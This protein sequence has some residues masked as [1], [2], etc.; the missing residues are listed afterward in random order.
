MKKAISL[1]NLLPLLL[2]L[3]LLLPGAAHA[4]SCTATMTDIVFANVNPIAGSDYYASGTL[5]VTCTV[6]LLGSAGAAGALLPSVS[7]CA[8]LG[9]ASGTRLMANGSATLPFNLY[10]DST[11][12]A[13]SVW[14]TGTA[15]GTSAFKSSGLALLSTGSGSQSFTVYGRIPG[16]AIGTVPTVGNASTD[17]SASFSGLGVLRYAFGTLL[18]PDCSSGASTA[19][20]FQ[21]RATV[22]NDCR[23][24]AGRLD[25]GNVG[26]LSAAVR[27]S[28]S[29]GVQCTAGS[30][31]QIGLNAGTYGSGATRYMKNAGSGETVSYQLSSTLDGV[32]WGDGAT[33]AGAAGTGTGV[34]QS[35]PLYGRVSAQTT[36][37]PGDYKDTVTATLYF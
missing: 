35:L 33:A 12:A 15:A 10:T 1:A 3:W 29:L 24:T 27:A 14:G 36:P 19:F 20:A 4:D 23:I 22:V 31:Y 34:V 5:T 21:A 18:S 16:S 37:S 17:Y 26:V 2:G 11:Y 30:A 9:G 6:S 13:A 8:T 25:F 32:N 28:T 7:I